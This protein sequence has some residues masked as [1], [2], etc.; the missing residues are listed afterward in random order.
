MHSTYK[1]YP[2]M[3][4]E[5]KGILKLK[6]PLNKHIGLNTKQIFLAQQVVGI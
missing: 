5:A 2:F 6:D 4:L 3:K 1:G